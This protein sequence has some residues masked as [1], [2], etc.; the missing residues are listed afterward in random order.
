VQTSLQ[1]LYTDNVSGMSGT[2]T[3]FSEQNLA[4]DNLQAHPNSPI[5]D[6]EKTESPGISAR[7]FNS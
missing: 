3:Y 6:T 7:A 4:C 5:L 1:E 2:H